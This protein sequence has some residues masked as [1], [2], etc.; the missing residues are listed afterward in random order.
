MNSIS[1]QSKLVLAASILA[2][3]IIYFCA[4][5]CSLSYF[6]YIET[7][8]DNADYL[9]ASNE[10]LTGQI[11]PENM[12]ALACRQTMG[13]L[14]AGL[15]W[16]SGMEVKTSFLVICIVS[17]A[18]CGFL[19]W[20]L[21]G[22]LPTAL[23]YVISI[24]WM[25]RMF[26]GGTEPIFMA[27]LLSAFLM[28]RRGHLYSCVILSCLATAIRPVGGLV[29][30]LLFFEL[31]N[32]KKWH[33]LLIVLAVGL[34]AGLCYYFV[35]LKITGH[36]TAAFTS[37]GVQWGK[38]YGSPINFPGAALY[39]GAISGE[40]EWVGWLAH[41][42]MP[43]LFLCATIWFCWRFKGKKDLVW[44]PLERSFAF[45]HSLFLMVYNYAHIWTHLGRWSVPSMPAF[46]Y[47][48]LQKFP[49]PAWLIAAG[50]LPS[51]ICQWAMSIGTQKAIFAIKQ[52]FSN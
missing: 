47:L 34:V 27:L 10:I 46:C 22:A 36:Q 52:L 12:G 43:F 3:H 39:H 13:C 25:P 15:S 35:G 5:Y 30:I 16:I 19:L 8:A 20:H 14:V 4:V 26:L 49:L 21:I 40:E 37:W 2:A 32:K 50:L 1:Y 29:L 48:F 9:S 33:Q 42:A 17:G 6:S 11:K 45:F 31:W 24:D 51:I 7:W 28:I 38:G 44:H 41:G 23:F 18:A